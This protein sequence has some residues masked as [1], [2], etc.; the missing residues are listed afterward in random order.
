ML[1][2]IAILTSFLLIGGF[3]TNI[4]ADLP[5]SSGM[6]MDLNG[7]A[8]Y[9]NNSAGDILKSIFES[10]SNSDDTKPVA[11]GIFDVGYK[12]T[13][14]VA[15]EVGLSLYGDKTQF[16]EVFEQNYAIDI[17][18]KGTFPMLEGFDAFGKIGAAM[19]HSKQSYEG[20]DYDISDITGFAPY[21]AVGLDYYFTPNFSIILQG[22][23]T[24][25]GYSSD[26]ETVPSF[27][28]LTLGVSYLFSMD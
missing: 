5:E 26:D 19:V 9:V 10:D 20:D 14:Y 15:A 8:A 2:K 3:T 13:D 25:Q 24:F 11:V 22:G 7:G 21:L 28:A 6:Y 17:A 18:L 1:K 23:G 16:G 4:L 12:F 27:L